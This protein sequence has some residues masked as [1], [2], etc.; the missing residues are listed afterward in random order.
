MTPTLAFIFPGQGSQTSGM[1]SEL[2]RQHPVVEQTYR[3][4][5]STL[6]YDLWTLVQDPDA[7]TSLNQTERTQPALLAASVALW[8][9][10]QAQT[11]RL[12][13]IMA[14]H[15]LGE[16]SAL[17]CAGAISYDDAI[18]L[19]ALRGRY[20]QQAVQEG[21]GAMAAIVGLDNDKIEEI[22]LLAAGREVL[23]P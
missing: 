19:V 13:C 23:S 10:W 22:C 11:D 12:P 18:S 20:M 3:Q 2:A 7:A 8:R 6:G 15:S 16:Y 4:A 17:V 5:S 21:E 9:I 14:G 1:L